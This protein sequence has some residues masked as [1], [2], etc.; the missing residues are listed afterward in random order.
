MS[1]P[2]VIAGIGKTAQGKLPGA[3]PL[4]LQIAA[5]KATLDDCGLNKSDIDGLLTQPG[6]TTPEGGYNYLR[7]GEA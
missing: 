5:I 3:T 1:Y 7:L 4:S 2:T 6:T